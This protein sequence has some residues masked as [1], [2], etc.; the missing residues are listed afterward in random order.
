[1][2]GV[3]E[4]VTSWRKGAEQWGEKIWERELGEEQWL[5]CK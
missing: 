2:T 3:E 1:M 5:A 4:E